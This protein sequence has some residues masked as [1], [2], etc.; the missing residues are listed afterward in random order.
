MMH[1]MRLEILDR[2]SAKPDDLE[3]AGILYAFFP[4]L[5]S[6][7]R[8]QVGGSLPL[9]FLVISGLILI[10]LNCFSMETITFRKNSF[11]KSNGHYLY[12]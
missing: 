4:F 2:L 7:K 6:F 1:E 10:K 12:H 11:N 8:T 5:C 3:F 9:K